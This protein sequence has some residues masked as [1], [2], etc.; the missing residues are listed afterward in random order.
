MSNDEIINE[1]F[2]LLDAF[3]LKLL[4]LPQN[5]TSIQMVFQSFRTTHRTMSKL[6]EDM[7]CDICKGNIEESDTLVNYYKQLRHLTCHERE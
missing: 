5:H 4:Q 7:V 6:S 2:E 3:R 1:A